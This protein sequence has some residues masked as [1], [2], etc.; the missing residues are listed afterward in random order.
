[1]LVDSLMVAVFVIVVPAVPEF[2]V[3]VIT[4]VA[5]ELGAIVPM[6]QTPVELANVPCDEVADTNVTPAGKISFATTPV[7]VTGP[8]AAAVNV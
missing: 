5:V 4:S 1:M 2:T 8:S 7:E 3:A 6:V